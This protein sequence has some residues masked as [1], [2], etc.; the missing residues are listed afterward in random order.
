MEKL[1]CS[2]EHY[3]MDVDD[4]NM[5]ARVNDALLIYKMHYIVDKWSQNRT[6]II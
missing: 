3:P 6:R 2:T 4:M 1:Q 5:E